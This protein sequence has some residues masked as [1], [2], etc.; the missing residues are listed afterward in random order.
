NVLITD[1]SSED[2][3]D[4]LPPTLS[5]NRIEESL[6]QMR[7]YE[8]AKWA[9]FSIPFELAGGL[10]IG[11]L[12]YGLVSEQ[13]RGAY[14]CFVDL[15]DKMNSRTTYVDEEQEAEIDKGGVQFGMTL[16]ATVE[17][18]DT[19][20]HRFGTRSMGAGRR[21]S[22]IVPLY[23]HFL[24][25]PDEFPSLTLR[26]STPGDVFPHS[27]PRAWTQ[28]PQ[29]RR[30]LQA[31]TRRN[32][33]LALCALLPQEKSQREMWAKPSGFRLIL[34]PF[35]DDIRATPIEGFRGKPHP[36]PLAIPLVWAVAR[37]VTAGKSVEFQA[38][39]QERHLPARLLPAGGSRL[40]SPG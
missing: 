25:S 28:A 9:L 14:K 1:T 21:V 27:K 15:G 5:I 19:E 39:V 2:G 17:D 3:S 6:D 35:V 33:S 36:L 23:F 40:S 38:R 13:K 8:S 18:E 24:M 32:A 30:S 37:A 29:F 7:F 4:L 26:S 20:E 34:L 11:I 31:L 22:T 16:G 10:V 12:G